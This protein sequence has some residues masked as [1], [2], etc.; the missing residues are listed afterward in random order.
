[1]DPVT[2]AQRWGGSHAQGAIVVTMQADARPQARSRNPVVAPRTQYPGFCV[3]PFVV[4]SRT[5]IG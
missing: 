3:S 1:V 4:I 2:A 5:G